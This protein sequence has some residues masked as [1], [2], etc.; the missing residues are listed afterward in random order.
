M[1]DYIV[2]YYMLNEI[3][4]KCLLDNQIGPRVLVCGSPLCGKIT[5]CHML[6]NYGLKLGWTPIY[7]DIDLDNEID[8]PGTISATVVDNLIPNDYL[9]DNSISF[10]NGCKGDN[11]NYFLYEK[12][13][14]ELAKIIKEKL[15]Y[16]LN[17]F[18]EKKKIDDDTKKKYFVSSVKPTLFASGLIIHCPN[19]NFEN[20]ENVK[21]TY[22]NILK[23]FDV[24]LV[25]VIENEKLKN[26]IINYCVELNKEVTV[27]LLSKL[28]FDFELN[29]NYLELK[30]EEEKYSLYFK[31]PNKNLQINK[32]TINLNKYKLFSI[33]SLN[34]TS[35]ILPIGASSNLNLILKEIKINSNIINKI[36]NIV[37][38]EEKE[39]SDLDN[40]FEKK[41][42]SY[43]DLFCTSPVE[44]FAVIISINKNSNEIT[45]CG[46]SYNLPHKYLILGELKFSKLFN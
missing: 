7:C 41:M 2:S 10:Y 33:E 5:F 31:G 14:V 22:L 27:N 32:I 30:E 21:K 6:L 38:L 46:P 42:N 9:I 13:L 44:Y 35:N 12:Q 8:I 4:N 45:I 24:N 16:D 1:K 37:S 20:N 39:I 18:K 19:F 40:N 17:L 28:N 3:R 34:N 23:E 29:Q 26:D 43:I 15:N 36:I 25:Y 11:I